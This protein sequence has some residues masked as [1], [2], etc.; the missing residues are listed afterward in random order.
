MTR[1]SND[2]ADPMRS[3]VRPCGKDPLDQLEVTAAC[4]PE[5]AEGG[6]DAALHHRIHIAYYNEELRARSLANVQRLLVIAAT[7]A[8]AEDAGLHDPN[9][10]GDGNCAVL[11][12]KALRY[13]KIYDRMKKVDVND[14][15]FDASR[16]L[17]VTWQ[18]VVP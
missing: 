11:A 18:K 3:P 16:F 12:K 10:K 15:A 6:E 8:A 9:R 1:E 4:D 5:S 17:G 7:T 14:P 13:R 2:H